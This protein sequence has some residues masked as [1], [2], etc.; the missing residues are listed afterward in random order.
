MI[1]GI[2]H[3][4]LVNAQCGDVRRK[5]IIDGCNREDCAERISMNIHSAFSGTIGWT[6]VCDGAAPHGD[7]ELCAGL[8]IAEDF[9]DVVAQLS[10]R[11][12]AAL[13]DCY[14]A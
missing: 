9:G 5:G 11:D 10:L 14:T 8:C 7:C 2:A 4:F 1:P 13:H 3:R 6:Q 12:R